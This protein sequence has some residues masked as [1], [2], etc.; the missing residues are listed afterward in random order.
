MFVAPMDSGL[1]ALLGITIVFT[2]IETLVKAAAAR[3][4][5]ALKPAAIA[6]AAIAQTAI[7]QAALDNNNL[8][9]PT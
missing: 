8:T 3:R 7:A 2:T 6:Q 9:H 1:E 5:G 4:A